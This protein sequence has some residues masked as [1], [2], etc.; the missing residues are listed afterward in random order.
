MEKLKQCYHIFEN[1]DYPLHFLI[2]FA[3]KSKFEKPF[4]QFKRKDCNCEF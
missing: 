1:L 2:I 3:V 4:Q